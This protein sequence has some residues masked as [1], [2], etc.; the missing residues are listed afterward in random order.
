[1]LRRF[2]PLLFIS[3]VISMSVFTGLPAS[4]QDVARLKAG[5]TWSNEEREELLDQARATWRSIQSIVGPSG[6]PGDRLQ[7]DQEGHWKPSKR[8][9]P[10][11]IA[12]YL[13][14][15][16]SARSLGLIDDAETDQRIGTTL[17][18]SST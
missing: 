12:S 11:D 16:L 18:S 14:S 9:S 3:M 15:T 5:F 4:G 6:L 17:A 13:W 1:M 2:R 7:P 10:T 8:T